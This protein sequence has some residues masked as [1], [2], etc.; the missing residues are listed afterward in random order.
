MAQGDEVGEFSVKRSVSSVLTLEK[1]LKYAQWRIQPLVYRMCEVGV[2]LLAFSF[3]YLKFNI[4]FQLAGLLIGPIFMGWLLNSAIERRFKAFD[5]DY[6]SFLL[7]LVA[8]LKTGMNAMGALEAGAQ[9]LE[10]DSMV[11]QEVMSMIER[12]RIR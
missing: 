9:G 4:I 5:A 12:L 2:S 7:S 10:E 1:K 11:R 3:F 6:P 8:L